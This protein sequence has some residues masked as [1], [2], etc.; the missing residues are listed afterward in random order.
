MLC[1]DIEFFMP[2][3]AAAIHRCFFV[4]MFS[5]SMLFDEVFISLYSEAFERFASFNIFAASVFAIFA[6]DRMSRFL[7]VYSRH[8][9]SL[10]ISTERFTTFIYYGFDAAHAFTFAFFTT[11]F[12]ISSDATAG[13]LLLSRFRLL[14]IFQRQPERLFSMFFFLFSSFYIGFLRVQEKSM[15]LFQLLHTPS[16]L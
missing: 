8:R 12:L 13:F 7:F 2:A 9:L 5:F 6:F 10:L 4:F 16:V 1:V 14:L 15:R 11:S 3:D